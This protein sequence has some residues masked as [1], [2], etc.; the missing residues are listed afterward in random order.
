VVSCQFA[1]ERAE[2]EQEREDLKEDIRK[3]SD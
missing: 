1:L 3:V 2:H